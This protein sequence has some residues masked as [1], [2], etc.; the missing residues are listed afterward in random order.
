MAIRDMFLLRTKFLIY[1]GMSNDI[2]QY[3]HKKNSRALFFARTKVLL[4]TAG[5]LLLSLLIA[6]AP[7]EDD[8]GG[9]GSYTVG[10]NVTGHTGEVSITLTY[11]NEN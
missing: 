4:A 10:G 9:S 1:G 6:C 3:L 8:G 2:Y 5:I 11:G 7:P